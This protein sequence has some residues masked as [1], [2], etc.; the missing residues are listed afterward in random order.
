MNLIIKRDEQINK[1]RFEIRDY[2]GNIKFLYISLDKEL[3]I[4]LSNSNQTP[5]SLSNIVSSDIN[6][7]DEIY[8]LIQDKKYDKLYKLINDNTYGQIIDIKVFKNLD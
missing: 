6:L 8:F 3:K 4:W 1:V 7:E 5:F 2:Y